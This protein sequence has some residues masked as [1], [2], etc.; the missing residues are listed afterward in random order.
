MSPIHSAWCALTLR[1]LAGR[2]TK[3]A[4][5]RAASAGPSAEAEASPQRVAA[6]RAR[7]SL[8]VHSF[9]ALLSGSR[10]CTTCGL[11]EEVEEM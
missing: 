7:S 9:R 2:A 1:R 8:H 3:R 6:L 10:T 4:A 11:V 5:K